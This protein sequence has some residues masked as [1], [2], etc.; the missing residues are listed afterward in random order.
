MHDSLGVGLVSRRASRVEHGTVAD[1]V[2]AAEVTEGGRSHNLREGS[3]RQV[4][5]VE[6]K[7]HGGQSQNC[8]QDELTG[9]ELQELEVKDCA[10]AVFVEVTTS[11][12]SI[13]A[14]V[15]TEVSSANRQLFQFCGA[16]YLVKNFLSGVRFTDLVDHFAV[17]ELV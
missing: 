12:F 14:V 9:E 10:H 5:A 6:E 16:C 15:A 3:V 1:G 2:R 17:T 4:R 13:A 11:T 8:Q 7:E